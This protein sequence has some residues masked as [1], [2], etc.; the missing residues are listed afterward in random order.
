M[1][2]IFH[3]EN[4]YLVP[5][6]LSGNLFP[7]GQ[8][9]AVLARAMQSILADLELCTHCAYRGFIISIIK[10]HIQDGDGDEP[11]A[12]VIWVVEL[13]WM[14]QVLVRQMLHLDR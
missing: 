6:F 8:Q 1:K 3:Q 11:H 7:Q 10:D 2:T 12:E 9:C 14:M 4:T 5:Q 13:A